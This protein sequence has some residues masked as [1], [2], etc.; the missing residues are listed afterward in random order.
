MITQKASVIYSFL[1]CFSLAVFTVVHA[2]SVSTDRCCTVLFS[3]G[4]ADTYKQAFWYAQSYTYNNI[5]Y[6]N[7]RHLF[8]CSFVSFNYPDATEGILRVKR[9]ETSFGQKNE[10]TRLY[11]AY[12]KTIKW[13]YERWN[14]CNI[15]LF[16]L[17]RG[18]SNIG[19]FAGTHDIK[20]HVKAIILESPYYI[21]SDVLSYMLHKNNLTWIPLS[22]AHTMAEMIFKRYTRFGVSPASAIENIPQ[23]MP[24]LLVCS[25]EDT[26]VPYTT[27]VAFYNKLK[28]SG[29]TNAYILILNHGKHAKLLSGPE[30]DIYQAVVHAFYK[31]YNLPY[32]C[33]I[34]AQG[35]SLLLQ[36]QPQHITIKVKR[37]K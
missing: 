10:I 5:K 12:N 8:S 11:S 32:N 2:K 17:S 25:K 24:I 33:A 16:G 26:T 18:A 15:I 6:Y 29:H 23:D 1:L 30:G 36:C 19:I 21:F 3:H 14:N 22:Y 7:D 9:Q 27:T 31:K 28:E 34:A 4:I 35:E 37:V 13:S 20:Q